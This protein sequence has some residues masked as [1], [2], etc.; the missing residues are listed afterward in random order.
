M[1]HLVGIPLC[2]RSVYIDEAVCIRRLGADDVV[3]GVVRVV[4]DGEVIVALAEDIRLGI[5]VV[6][7]SEQVTLRLDGEL[8][9]LA[10]G[11][12]FRLIEADQLDGGLFHQIFALIVA[13]RGLRVQLHHRLARHVARVGDGDV[14]FEL[15]RFGVVAHVAQRLLEGGVREAVAEGI[16]DLVGVVPLAHAAAGARGAVCIAAAEDVVF[17]P[18]LIILI[19]DVDALR[20]EGEVAAGIREGAL[21]TDDGSLHLVAVGVDAR[22][23][24]GVDERGGGKGVV[25]IGIDQL[26]REVRL[27]RKQLRCAQSAHAA[28][29]AREHAGV[30]AVLFQ[31]VDF[32]HVASVQKDDELIEIARVFCLFD[33]L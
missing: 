15:V 21:R 29:E 1:I 16:R 30:Y 9:A 6:V 26:T 12:Q 28:D 11:E 22:I 20:L 27:A 14:Y 24:V 8:F 3:D 10:G 5:R 2:G 7:R 18:G 13:V 32:H 23:F 4:A 19:A 33:H 17:V 25:R 31:P